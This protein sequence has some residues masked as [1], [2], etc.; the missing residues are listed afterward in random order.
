METTRLQVTTDILPCIDTERMKEEKRLL[1]TWSK[2]SIYYSYYIKQDIYI[3]DLSH[4]KN[5]VKYRD[6]CFIYING[7]HLIHFRRVTGSSV[8]MEVLSC[9]LFFLQVAP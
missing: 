7:T 4:K 8:E 3:H 9:S 1:Y 2:F 6:T 5:G